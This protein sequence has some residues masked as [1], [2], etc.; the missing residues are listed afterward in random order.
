MR[1]HD[2]T[3]PNHPTHPMFQ[4]I[5]WFLKKKTEGNLHVTRFEKKKRKKQGNLHVTRFGVFLWSTRL[6]PEKKCEIYLGNLFGKYI[7]GIKESSSKVGKVWGE[8][9]YFHKFAIDSNN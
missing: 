7:W 8:L 3:H 2:L 5:L 1:R 6:L 9:G 4:L